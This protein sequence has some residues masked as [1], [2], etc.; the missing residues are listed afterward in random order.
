MAAV[1]L[2]SRKKTSGKPTRLGRLSTK[3][4][5]A[6]KIRVFA[7]VDCW[8]QWILYP[9]HAAIF[10]LLGRIP[11]DGTFDQLRP[12]ARMKRKGF[13]HKKSFLASYDLSAATD[14]LPLQVQKMVLGPVLGIH[15]AET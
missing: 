5:A 6:G 15:L 9:L 14:R 13:L 8:T 7:I 1:N 11:Q 4:E 3:V 10:S 12:I 2:V